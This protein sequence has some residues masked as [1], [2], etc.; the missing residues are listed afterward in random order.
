MQREQY[1][2]FDARKSKGI[3]RAYERITQSDDRGLIRRSL[4]LIDRRDFCIRTFAEM[5]IAA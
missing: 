4:K 2:A 1:A 5:N 3:T